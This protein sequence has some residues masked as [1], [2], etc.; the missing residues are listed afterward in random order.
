M[1][2]LRASMK[3]TTVTLASVFAIGFVLF[4]GSPAIARDS[5]GA[6]D[7]TADAAGHTIAPPPLC[8]KSITENR[9]SLESE[10]MS[11]DRSAGRGQDKPAHLSGAKEPAPPR[12]HEWI[13][14][15][16]RSGKARNPFVR[17]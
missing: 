12:H 5:A 6:T 7:Y 3:I 8:A 17:R 13:E 9:S 16:F 1:S 2:I 4:T 10:G 11:W 15:Y 14:N